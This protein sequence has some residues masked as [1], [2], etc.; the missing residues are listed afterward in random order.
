MKAWRKGKWKSLNKAVFLKQPA[1]SKVSSHISSDH[2]GENGFKCKIYCGVW[3]EQTY[4]VN[5]DGQISHLNVFPSWTDSTYL[6]KLL[7][8]VNFEWKM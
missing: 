3:S 6:F 5:F 8:S 2:K 1:K 7:L 4:S